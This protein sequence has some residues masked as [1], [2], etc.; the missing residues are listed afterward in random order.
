MPRSSGWSA[1]PTG[2]NVGVITPTVY[3][4]SQIAIHGYPNVPTYPASHGCV[5]TQLRDQDAIYPF[6][7]V[8]SRVYIY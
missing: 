4:G 3:K 7:G 5:R 1:V 8:G 6:L 2:A